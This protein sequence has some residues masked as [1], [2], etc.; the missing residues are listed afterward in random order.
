[1]LDSTSQDWLIA[2]CD[3]RTPQRREALSSWEANQGNTRTEAS[4]GG[5]R[6]ERA[7]E[8]GW[9]T[10]WGSAKT[11]PHQTILT[12]LLLDLSA[13]VWEN[14]AEATDQGQPIPFIFRLFS[15]FIETGWMAVFL[16]FITF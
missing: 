10:L 6:N 5:I 15:T 11:Y 4:Y 16:N 14:R 1:M 3:V 7:G 2:L 8:D 13:I 12:E 9:L